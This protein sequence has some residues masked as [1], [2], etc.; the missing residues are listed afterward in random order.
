M[1]VTRFSLGLQVMLIA[2]LLSGCQSA[3]YYD[4][5]DQ[6]PSVQN[7]AP[8][9]PVIELGSSVPPPEPVAEPSHSRDAVADVMLQVQEMLSSNSW[10]QA[11]DMSERGLRIDHRNG[12]FYQAITEAYVGLGMMSDAL[13]F[14]QLGLRYCAAGTACRAKLEQVIG[15]LQ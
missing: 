7:Q 3:V 15:T 4:D 13:G 14:A 8:P 2:A 6:H 12:Y 10:Q 11:L 5:V 1:A 9:A